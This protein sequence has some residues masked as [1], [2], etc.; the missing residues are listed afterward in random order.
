MAGAAKLGDDDF[1][2]GQAGRA[3]R[4][5]VDPTR[6]RR[7]GS[8]IR[9]R[10]IRA[11]DAD[12]GR[13]HESV[14]DRR[15]EVCDLD[16]DNARSDTGDDRRVDDQCD[17]LIASRAILGNQ[18]FNQHLPPTTSPPCTRIAPNGEFGATEAGLLRAEGW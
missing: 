4:R 13:P 5:L 16:Q 18:D 17:R 6:D 9:R 11:V 15:R 12:G 8:P 10:H 1:R 14:L 7:W 3:E 2:G